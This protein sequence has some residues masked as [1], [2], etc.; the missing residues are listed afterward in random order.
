MRN[1]FIVLFVTVAVLAFS[2]ALQA[3]TP[4]GPGSAADKPVPNL[5]GI[6]D[7]PGNAARRDI[8]GEPACSA[9]LGVQP[10]AARVDRNLDE[11]QMLPWAEQQYKSV[12][13]GVQD[14]TA[15]AR[16]EL[17]PFW[18]GCMPEGPAESTRRRGFELVQ[19]PDVVLLLYGHDHA[20][21]RAYVD[22]RGHPANLKTTWMGHSTGKYEGDTLVVDTV[23]INDKAW[24]DAQGHPHTDALRLT[25]RFRRADQE[26]LEI[27]MTV[28][29]PKTYSKP[30]RKS[31]IH[32]LRTP[33]PNVWDS[34][35]CEE[36]LQMD[37]HYS[38]ESKK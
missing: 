12:R 22:G 29:D 17:R 2:P 7:A 1:R 33:G 19:F 13:E 30:W 3:Q 35:E 37:T 4:A 32:K 27:E 21:R 38:A 8:C 18:G 11:P 36:L 6:W 20:V 15:F 14:P 25:E 24:I 5:N 26:T 31:I 10:P 9:L 16:G 28:D 34:S 23:G